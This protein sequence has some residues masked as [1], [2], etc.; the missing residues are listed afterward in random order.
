ML[1]F[2]RKKRIQYSLG[3][4]AII[5]AIWSIYAV[6]L[7]GPFLWDD[8]VM[9]QQNAI[10]QHPEEWATLFTSSAFGETFDKD[11]F[12]RPLQILTYM[13]DAALWDM[14]ASGFHITSIL[15]HCINSILFFVFLGE[16][17]I[18][19]VP[20]FLVSLLFAVHPI[21]IEC[22]TYISGRGDILFLTFALLSMICFLKGSGKKVWF[23]I[24][25]GLFFGLGL[26]TKENITPLPVLLGLLTL[27]V[28]PKERQKAGYIASGILTALAGAF[29]IWRLIP[30]GSTTKTLSLIADADFVHRIMT[31]P[32]I[33]VTYCRLLVWPNP[34][35]MEYHFVE[36]SLTSPYILFGLPVVIA[37]FVLA[38]L[39]LPKKREI[40]CGIAW[41]FIALAPVYNLFP[42]LP[43]TLR[44]HWVVLPSIGLF[45]VLAIGIQTVYEKKGFKLAIITLVGLASI[46]LGI[47]TYN[48]NLNWLDPMTLYA[49]DLQY[50]P[51]SFLLYNNVGVIAFRDGNMKLAE[52]SFQT[53]INVSPRQSYG[54]AYNNLGVIVENQGR[55]S[56]AQ[57]HFE[58]SIKYSNYEFGYVN[59]ARI[60]IKKNE[61]KAAIKSLEE[62]KLHYQSSVQVRYFLGVSYYLD[63]NYVKAVQELDWV[64]AHAGNYLATDNLLRAMGK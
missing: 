58:A 30:G 5:A 48:R 55:I 49:H 43:A 32:Y 45:W 39:G 18:A 2:L 54:T 20:A 62:G 47:T 22:A 60:L 59:L 29:S 21:H 17:G 3:F 24:L 28:V 57:R 56:D 27:S 25:S 13:S 41:F 42:K 38:Y 63:N 64:K 40:A 26:I 61:Y 7:D 44:E 34:L 53:S 14:E 19:I 8:E 50:E 52:E 1:P 10:I 15:I 23:Y 37:V 51:L 16:I 36:H 12:Y 33:I 35:H 46:A 6:T 9:V 4:L 11:K 31:L